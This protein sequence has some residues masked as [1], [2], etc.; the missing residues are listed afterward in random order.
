[1][2]LM[3]NLIV[4]NRE[5]TIE[6]LAHSRILSYAAYQFNGYIIGKMHQLIAA[7]LE[8]V[9][10]GDI[11]RLMI[12]AP[13]RHGKTALVG[14]YFPAWY[15]GRNPSSHIIYTTYNQERGNDVGRRV[16]D[17]IVS[18]NFQRIFPACSVLKDSKSIHNLSTAQHGEY[19]NVGIGGAIVGRGAN[20]L[21]I[22]DPI[23]SREEAESKSARQKIQTWY[24]GVAYTRVMPGGKI[25]VINTRWHCFSQDTLLLTT[26]GWIAANKIKKEH[27][28]I[29]Q[30]GI[31]P[32]VRME[33][34]QHNGEIYKISIYGTPTPLVVTGN[35]K[36]LTSDGWKYAEQLTKDD[37]LIVPKIN[38]G[39]I[40]Q[41]EA[42]KVSTAKNNG[43]LTGIQNKVS[44]EELKT[45]LDSG[46]TYDE[47]AWHFGYVGRGTINK[48]ITLYGLNRNTNTV[49]PP[50]M[51]NDP[52]FWR[53]IGY[54][55]AEG[56]LSKVRKHYDKNHYT[57]VVL[58]I[59]S[60]EKWIADDIADV[61]SKYNINVSTC[62]YK[63]GNV[64]KVQF[65]CWQIAQYLKTYFGTHAYG[66]HLPEW[67]S[68]LSEES[69]KELLIGYFRGDGCFSDKLGYR[70]GSVSL[71]LLTSVQQLLVSMNIP[72]GIMAGRKKG[73]QLFA[74][75]GQNTCTANVKNSYEL[76][77]HESYIPWMDIKREKYEI[78]KDK[79][80]YCY[81][82]QINNNQL[83]LRIK[84]IGIQQYDGLVYDFETPSHEITAAGV[85][86]HN[87]Q[88][89][90]GYLLAEHAHENWV[91]LDLKAF[92]EPG[93][94][95][96]R[97][98]G[99]A[100][101]PEFRDVKELN[102][103]KAALGPREW[104]AQ[105]QQR[106]TAVG[107]GKVLYEWL[108]Y[109][110]ELPKPE[111][112]Q[113]VVASWDTAY[114][115]DQ[116]NDPTAGTIWAITHNGYYLIDVINKRLAFPDLVK[117]VKKIHELYHPTAHLIEGRATGQSLVQELKRSTT[118]PVIE[119]ST[120]NINNEIRF[121]AITT[122]FESGQVW[123]PK[124]AHWLSETEDQICSFPTAPHD[125]I[126]DSTSQ[127]LNWVNKPRYVPRPSSKLY[128]K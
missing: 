64:I 38:G 51:L 97:E 100:L 118:I 106:P 82:K 85:I 40:P 14:E 88:D 91:V 37:W 66:K 23:K 19:F 3:S 69:K 24:Q 90:S 75:K 99:T 2:N 111:D 117:E 70:V 76:R 60:H 4:P 72:N 45:L 20:V 8:A 30:N 95:L 21:L 68:S 65:S 34:R 52:G 101:W 104:N 109:Y 49:A 98:E 114:K 17:Q 89:L 84:K 22:D 26:D 18:E 120:K 121:D 46:K 80:R 27:L 55:L 10:R 31:E 93:D 53:V 36:V 58:S 50:E 63:K 29:T 32:I 61:L 83:E 47:C 67:I 41:F 94:I 12:F 44:K 123:F 13:P 92:A 42:P 77:I 113:K 102:I 71:H 62:L 105:F 73:K 124:Q 43:N 7:Y 9:E 78:R 107:G 116:I 79:P 39:K 35:H 57:I 25:V 15:L 128:W 127:F 5:P 6:E 33:N 125:D 1:M 115:P 54:W 87:S 122:L 126:A 28:F 56:S 110:E 112:V 59:G 103:I 96:E 86:V 16:R 119:I 81:G 11:T 48:Y 108:K 74:I